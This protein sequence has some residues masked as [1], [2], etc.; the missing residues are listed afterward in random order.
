MQNSFIATG[1]KISILDHNN[2]LT[3][4]YTAVVLGDIDKCCGCC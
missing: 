4:E 3:Q 1:D 2:T